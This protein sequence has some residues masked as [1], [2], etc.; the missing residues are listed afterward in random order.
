MAETKL[1]A[2]DLSKILPLWWNIKLHHKS[3]ITLRPPYPPD[4]KEIFINNL[5]VIGKAISSE[6]N[7]SKFITATLNGWTFFNCVSFIVKA[8]GV[9]PKVKITLLKL[10][11]LQVVSPALSS[12]HRTA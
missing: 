10:F 1:L 8:K 9:R 7:E 6:N 12:V 3:K 5:L 2:C 11:L 4:H